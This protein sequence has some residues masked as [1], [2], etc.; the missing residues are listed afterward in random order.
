MES[1]SCVAMV[2]WFL[3]GDGLCFFGRKR[4]INVRTNFLSLS[5]KVW[6]E[7]GGGRGMVGVRPGGAKRGRSRRGPMKG[8]LGPFC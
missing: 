7:V 6:V 5:K 2:L 3:D 8:L 1:T 4:S